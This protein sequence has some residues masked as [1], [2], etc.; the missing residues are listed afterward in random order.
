MILAKKKRNHIGLINEKYSDLLD[1]PDTVAKDIS[2]CYSSVMYSPLEDWIRYDFNDKWEK[3]DGKLKLGL[4][5][6]ETDDTTLFRKS[7]VYSSAIIGKALQENIKF[8]IISQL[9]PRYKEQK[10]MFRIIIDK[11]LEYFGVF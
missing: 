3:Y 11:I 7:D 1:D 9:I 4:Y 5:Y 6:I 10:N 8:K 2:K